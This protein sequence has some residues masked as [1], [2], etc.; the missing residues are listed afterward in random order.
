MEPEDSAALLT[1]L[2]SHFERVAIA[3]YEQ[4]RLQATAHPA[5]ATAQGEKPRGETF[6]TFYLSCK[7]DACNLLAAGQVEALC[8]IEEWIHS[9]C[10]CWAVQRIGSQAA[11][12][13]CDAAIKCEP[14]VTHARVVLVKPKRKRTDVQVP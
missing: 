6:V 9:H 1:R 12:P 7:L 2:A 5:S 3:I 14:N 13:Y 4:V 8:R 10:W 11:S